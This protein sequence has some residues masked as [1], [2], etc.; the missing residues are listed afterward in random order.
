MII[1][2]IWKKCSK[3]PT[4][5]S[6]ADHVS[7][8]PL[9][10]LTSHYSYKSPEKLPPRKPELVSLGSLDQKPLVWPAI[11]PKGLWPGSLC[12]LGAVRPSSHQHL[13]RT[14]PQNPWRKFKKRQLGFE[15]PALGS[16]KVW[17]CPS[18]RLIR[19]VQSNFWPWH[20]YQC[21]VSYSLFVHL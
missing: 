15:A 13:T 12:F 18:I 21:L 17:P 7:M 20:S 11:N 4:S 1:P 10:E 6:L 19:L 2:N 5:Y 3:P 8:L 9:S 16:L 14:T